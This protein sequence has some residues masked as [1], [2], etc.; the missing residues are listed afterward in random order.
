[1]IIS[2]RANKHLPA[3]SVLDI[4]PE[5]F[6]VLV[7]ISVSIS[8]VDREPDPVRR[9]EPDR[10]AQ[11]DPHGRHHRLPRQQQVSCDWR[12]PVT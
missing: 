2:P 11:A 3:I 8:V 10:G 9:Q 1:M 7:I 6:S 5:Q 12:R 4:E